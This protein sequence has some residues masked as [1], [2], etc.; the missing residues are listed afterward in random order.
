M[1]AQLSQTMASDLNLTDGRVCHAP[2]DSSDLDLVGVQLNLTKRLEATRG[3]LSSCT[4][5]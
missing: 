5:T 3:S 1:L 2:L 4:S